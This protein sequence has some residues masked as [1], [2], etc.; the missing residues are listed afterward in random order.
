MWFD[1]FTVPPLQFD[2]LKVLSDRTISLILESLYLTQ[3]GYTSILDGMEQWSWKRKGRTKLSQ[4]C[5]IDVDRVYF[6]LV[7]VPE[8]YQR[9][10]RNVKKFLEL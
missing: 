6:P 9:K 8:G 4:I 10:T 5:R 2:L 1:G 7:R 3:M